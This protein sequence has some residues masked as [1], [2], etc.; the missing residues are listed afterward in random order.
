MKVKSRRYN[1]FIKIIPWIIT[2]VMLVVALGI[3]NWY[4]KLNSSH[5]V[6]KKTFRYT[7]GV[8]VEYSKKLKL[9]HDDKSTKLVDGDESIESDGTPLVYSDC[10][11]LLIPVSMGYLN[12]KS[13]TGVK[14]VNYFS[15][16]YSEKG[17][18][19]IEHDDKKTITERGI[20]YDGSGTYIFMENMTLMIGDREYRVTPLTYAKV[21][22]RSEMELYDLQN[23]KY[24]YITLTESEIV[25]KSDNGYSINLGTGVINEDGT[26]RILFA[27]IE[28]M[29]V[30]E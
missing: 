14:R 17:S 13:E 28:A 3:G 11:K 16:L 5:E 21:F 7:M 30:L 8:K 22:Y 12:P 19:V 26:Q 2:V 4:F 18:Y 6:G 10:S 1:I 27:D 20:L 15:K 23:D 24:E 9:K 25:A 29:G